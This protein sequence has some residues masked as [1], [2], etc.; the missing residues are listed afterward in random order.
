MPTSNN[1]KE[2][3]PIYKPEFMEHQQIIDLISNQ[4]SELLCADIIKIT[5]Q[6]DHPISALKS[7]KA[8]GTNYSK[9]IYEQGSLSPVRFDQIFSDPNDIRLT[10]QI[11]IY[12]V[13]KI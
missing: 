12:L 5:Q 1:F 2:L 10:Y 7:L 13:R 3:A 11:G 4:R 6:F 8:T 9:G